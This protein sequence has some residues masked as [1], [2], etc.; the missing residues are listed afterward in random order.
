MVLRVRERERTI[1]KEKDKR[2]INS[3]TKQAKY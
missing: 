2:I 1:V 3:N